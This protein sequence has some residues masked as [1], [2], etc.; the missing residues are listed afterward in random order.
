MGE[1]NGFCVSSTPISHVGFS[2][3]T[4]ECKESRIG[5]QPIPVP[6]NV[7]VNLEGQDIK[8]K[9][10]LGELA[11][12]CPREVIVEREE[13]GVLRVRKAVETRRANQMHG[14][15]RYSFFSF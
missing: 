13:P 12:V 15:F 4:V 9:G 8:V 14:L 5:K 10:P 7:T 6:S 3:K 1:R 2:R 11:L